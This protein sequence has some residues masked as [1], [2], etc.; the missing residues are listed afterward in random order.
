MK[1]SIWGLEFDPASDTTH[2]WVVRDP[3]GRLYVAVPNDDGDIDLYSLALD[4]ADV[5]LHIHQSPM[6]EWA[7][8]PVKDIT[9]ATA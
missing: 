3:K 4:P 1:L 6:Q 8:T 9:D 2:A 7:K 5:P